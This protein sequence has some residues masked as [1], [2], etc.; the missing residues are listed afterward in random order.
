MY[1][2]QADGDEQTTEI[3]SVLKASTTA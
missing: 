1:T 3:H 2:V